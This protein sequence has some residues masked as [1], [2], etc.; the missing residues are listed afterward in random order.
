[1]SYDIS[2]K[3]PLTGLTAIVPD[4]HDLRGGTYRVGGDDEAHLNVT[5]NYS[6]HYRRVIG[7]RGIRTIYGMTG[8]ESLPVLNAA[9]QE[10]GTDRDDDYWEPTEGN[11]RAALENLL[12]L[13]RALP[14]CVWDGD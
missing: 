9:I 12:L 5:Y 1:M 4:G 10:L 7:P 6:P 14:H 3:D 11:A 8:A 2:L 13:A